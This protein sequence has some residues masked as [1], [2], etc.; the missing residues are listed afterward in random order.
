MR[1]QGNGACQNLATYTTCYN[2]RD[3]MLDTKVGRVGEDN[4]DNGNANKRTQEGPY[5]STPKREW[6]FVIAVS[7]N[8]AS[9]PPWPFVEKIRHRYDRLM[10]VIKRGE[11]DKI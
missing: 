4:L 8:K 2:H 1:K 6:F 9:D 7:T 10:K 11:G 5:A 3:I